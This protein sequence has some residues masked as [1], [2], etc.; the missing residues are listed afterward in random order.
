MKSPTRPIP[1]DPTRAFQPSA[2]RGALWLVGQYDDAL[3]MLRSAVLGRQGLHVL[4]GEPGTGKTLLAHA[5]AVRVQ[6]DGV[7]IG[8]LL[9]PILEGMDLR[10][11]LAEAFA[12]PPEFKDG[13]E[14]VEQF[15]RFVD[16]TARA[17]RRLLLIVDEKQNLTR[18]V[19]GEL[20]RLLY[21]RQGDAASLSVLLIGDRTLL[22]TLRADGVEPDVLCHLR[23][24]TREQT[25]EYVTHRLRAAGHRRQLFTPPAL[26]K[27]WVVS[28][29]VPRAINALCIDALIGLRTT[30]GRK[31]TA[32]LI[33]RPL[34]EPEPTTDTE[35]AVV[36]LAAPPAAVR[37][38]PRPR[39]KRRWLSL[40]G[41]GAIA[42][43]L[44][45]ALMFTGSD[46]APWLSPRPAATTASP[47]PVETTSATV[48][49]TVTD[50]EVSTAEPT[51][52]AASVADAVP[53][54][55]LATAPVPI[56]PPAAIAP[57]API[58]SPAPT[59]LPA[60]PARPKVSAAAPPRESRATVS[61]PRRSD[62]ADD[63]GATIDWLLKERQNPGGNPLGRLQ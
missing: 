20:R 52:P 26:R 42:A 14:F 45:A 4:V 36:S 33:D 11:A 50:R 7:V 28:E 32:S 13:D 1:I 58:V 19:I 25:V 9:Y 29:G 47:I 55:P 23:P 31:V 6:Q 56:A 41:G 5:L 18:D 10:T 54:P 2:D 40:A 38:M 62:D 21:G 39:P 24:L 57:P 49:A 37:T 53:T 15:G 12:L 3:R 51:A 22:D 63:S 17:G 8:R 30:K 61:T 43:T 35:V 44:A 60:A 48:S 34:R 46:Q 27:I 59:A 16:D